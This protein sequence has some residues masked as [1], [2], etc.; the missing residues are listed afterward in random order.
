MTGTGGNGVID[1]GVV[2]GNGVIMFLYVYGSFHVG[3]KMINLQD[4]LII[5]IVISERDGDEIEG[6]LVRKHEWESTT[7]KASNR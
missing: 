2:I 1:N 3:L 4:S 5:N 7:K 6:M